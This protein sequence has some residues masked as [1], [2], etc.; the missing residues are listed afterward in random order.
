MARAGDRIDNPV[1]RE[2]LVFLAT[3]EETNGELLRV[4]HVFAPGGSVPAVHLHPHQEERFEILSGSPR[5]RIGD[6]ERTARS[7]DVVT[8]AAKTPHTWWNAGHDETR[9]LIE[10]RP[11]L[12]TEEIFEI[13]FGLGRDGRLNKRG[14]P[15]PVLGAVIAREFDHEA[16]V[17]PS[18]EILLTRLPPPLIR[19]LIDLL[20]PLGRLLGYPG[21]LRHY[22]TRSSTASTDASSRQQ[23]R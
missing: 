13:L 1:T 21:L 16:R 8:V 5:F 20:A 15:N 11:A 14:I 19:L 17:A 22:S 12:R 3:A 18:K 4:E 23:S 9:V 2:R 6:E 10:F 7:G